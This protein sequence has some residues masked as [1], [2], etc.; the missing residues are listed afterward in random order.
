MPARLE[1]A[2]AQLNAIN[3]PTV[4]PAATS[5]KSVGSERANRIR[6]TPFRQVE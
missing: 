4:K 3:A 2:T 6:V 1:F 5:H